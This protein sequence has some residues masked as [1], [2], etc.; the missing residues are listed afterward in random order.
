M[1]ILYNLREEL[2]L[3]WLLQLKRVQKIIDPLNMI[4]ILAILMYILIIKLEKMREI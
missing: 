1:L 2:A 3:S 4:I